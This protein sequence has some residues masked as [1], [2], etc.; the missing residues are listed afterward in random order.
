MEIKLLISK[1]K[2]TN[3]FIEG[4]FFNSVENVY[5]DTVVGWKSSG[6]RHSFLERY[7]EKRMTE[8]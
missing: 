4:N 6:V 3:S 8:E 7:D 5:L 2:E 1:L